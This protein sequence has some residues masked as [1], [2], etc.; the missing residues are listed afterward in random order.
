MRSNYNRKRKKAT[1]DDNSRN[2]FYRV[3]GYYYDS[4]EITEF[5]IFKHKDD[6]ESMFW[7]MVSE[8]SWIDIFRY[9]DDELEINWAYHAD[10][11]MINVD[12]LRTF[13]PEEKIKKHID[14]R[15]RVYEA[16]GK[17][18]P[19]VYVSKETSPGS[20]EFINMYIQLPPPGVDVTSLAITFTQ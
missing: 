8:C 15:N 17:Y 12:Y 11:D 7:E 5:G 3:T 6:A 9:V 14:T 13:V 10:I 16:V 4:N 1:M 20:G 18:P 19:N 2:I